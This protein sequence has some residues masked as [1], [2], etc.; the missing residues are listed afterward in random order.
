VPGYG[1]GRL[2]VE[3]NLAH[4]IDR[5]VLG[6]HNFGVTGT[7]DPEG[8][9]STIPAIATTLLGVLGGHILCLR[10]RL[11]QR[12]ALLFLTGILLLAAALVCETRMPIN[13]QIW[14]DS[15]SLSMAGLDFAVLA[16][17]AWTIDGLGW[18]AVWKPLAV[19]GRNALAVYFASELLAQ[20][21]DTLSLHAWLYRTWFAPLASPPRASLLYS[22]TF[23]LLMYTVAHVMYRRAWFLRV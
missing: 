7:W 8:I 23:A 6:R 16:V 1:P 2:D 18:A 3:G 10:R 19:F 14:T 15:F 21:L 12:A 20:I 22:I 9:L 11:P 4:Y 17:L 5:I 13:K